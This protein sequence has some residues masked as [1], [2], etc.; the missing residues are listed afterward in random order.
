MENETTMSEE[1][2][3]KWT[4]SVEEFAELAIGENSLEITGEP[5]VQTGK[6]GD[7][8]FIPT[9]LGIWRISLSSPI[10][11]ELKKVDEKLGSL[12][13]VA[14]T[15]AKTGKDKDTRYSIK[16]L[17]LPQQNKHEQLPQG[18]K[19]LNLEQLTPEQQ[20]ELNKI[21]NPTKD[22]QQ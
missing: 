4:E 16:K 15:V 5:Y 20:A 1:S 12:K 17:V 9:S 13:Y 6:F 18:Q 21:L 22:V 3:K 8:L 7:R 10:A 11:R 2:A 14:L 19:M